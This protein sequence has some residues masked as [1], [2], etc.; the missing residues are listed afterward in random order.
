MKVGRNRVRDI[1]NY[2]V[3]DATAVITKSSNVGVVKIA[4]RM[5]RAVLWQLYGQLGFGRPTDARFPGERSGVLP[6]FEG[7]SRF[8]HATLAFG[9]GLNVTTLQL[10]QAYSVLANDGV[11]HPVTLIKR[12]TIPGGERVFSEKTARQARLMMETVVSEKGTA[13]RAAVPGYRV[14]GKTGTAKKATARG[15]AKGKYQS[16][17]AGLAP[18]SDPRFVMVVM[19]DEPKGKQYYGGIVAAP[20]FSKVMQAALRLYN[21]APDDPQGELL[22]AGVGA[23]R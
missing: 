17:F 20:T 8:E 7:W 18:V 16:V 11:R 2:G 21:V 13:S 9:Y 6:H 4:Q 15:Y 10:A 22:L 14:A 3:L 1:R 5:D 23:K 12:D 19:I